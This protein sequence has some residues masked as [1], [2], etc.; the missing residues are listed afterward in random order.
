MIRAKLLTGVGTIVVMSC[1]FLPIQT[2]LASPAQQAAQTDEE[3]IQAEA[4][5]KAQ[6]Q[7]L[8][9]TATRFPRNA[10]EFDQMYEKIKNWERWGP[11]DQLG[12]ANLISQDKRKQAL[13]LARIGRVISLAHPVFTESVGPVEQ[14]GTPLE[15]TVNTG[16]VGNIGFIA[17]SY[18]VSYHGV[19]HTHFDTLCHFSYKGRTYNGYPTA[20]V[21]TKHGCAKLGVENFKGGVVTRGVLIDI[22]RLRGVPYL[23]PGTPVFVEDFEAWEKRSGVKIASGDA[24]FLRTG[25][26]ARWAA[27]GPWDMLRSEAGLHASVAPWLKQRGVAII[28][29]DSGLDVFPSAVK[30]VLVPMHTLV[31]SALGISILD[32]QDLEE[33][34]QTAAELHRWEFLLSFAP[35]PVPG[36]TG[37]PINA[38]AV[39]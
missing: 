38:L 21:Y 22:P 19:L 31:L 12:A 23:E 35:M 34:A 18:S 9:S 11:D 1:T 24:I 10:E 14:Y 28:G 16:T 20:T 5:S 7:S 17:D 32:N 33:L 27:L 30:D 39:F 15:Q 13:A 25:R 26:W 37:S 2:A 3:H 29:T 8:P 4:E 36:G 6:G